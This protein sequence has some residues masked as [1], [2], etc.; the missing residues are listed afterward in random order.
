MKTQIQLFAVFISICSCASLDRQEVK[1]LERIQF[2]PLQIRPELESNNLRIDVIRQSTQNYSGEN[3][4]SYTLDPYHKMGF[5]LGNG[6]F[7][8]LNY[9]LSL[10]LDYLLKFNGED[11]FIIK[12]TNPRIPNRQPIVYALEGDSLF[13][14]SSDKKKR[15][16][17]FNKTGNM[18]SLSFMKDNRQLHAV[19][20]NENGI[21]YFTNAKSDLQIKTPVNNQYEVEKKRRT[22][23]YQLI[24]GAIYLRDLYSVHLVDANRIIE[25]REMRRNRS[26]KIFTMER[27]GDKIFIY[28]RNFS[29]KK[30]TLENGVVR[31]FL[32]QKPGKEFQLVTEVGITN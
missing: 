10:R 15:K 25:I 18:D 30:I 16:Y 6:I 3:F 20:T 1:K 28:G 26:R 12:E 5:D 27:S 13:I 2:E 8:D 4:W 22:E 17:I 9:N 7:F 31:L 24:D 19:V 32:D 14:S 29:G 21:S 11:E 23:A